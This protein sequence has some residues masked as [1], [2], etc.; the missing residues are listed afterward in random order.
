MQASLFGRVKVTG[1]FLLGNPIL[2][3]HFPWTHSV[4]GIYFMYSIYSM[5]VETSRSLGVL[6]TGDLITKSLKQ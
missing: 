6:T 1:G 2:K 5:R 3:P 4:A